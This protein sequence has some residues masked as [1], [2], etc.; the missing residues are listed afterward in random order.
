MY[1]LFRKERKCQ[2]DLSEV[3]WIVMINQSEE[4]VHSS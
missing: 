3:Q 2:K 4:T 1:S